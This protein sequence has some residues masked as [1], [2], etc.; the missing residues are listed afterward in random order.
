MTKVVQLN[1]KNN[2]T[3]LIE[4]IKFNN[5]LCSVQYITMFITKNLTILLLSACAIEQMEMFKKLRHPKPSVTRHSA[6][7]HVQEKPFSTRFL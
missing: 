6:A 1:C 2:R 7:F 5:R 3:Y 4:T